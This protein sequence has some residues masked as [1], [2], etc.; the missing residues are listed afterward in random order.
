MIICSNTESPCIDQYRV[1]W[2]L[3][4]SPLQ[5]NKWRRICQ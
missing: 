3:H 2:T 1:A 5:S 4:W